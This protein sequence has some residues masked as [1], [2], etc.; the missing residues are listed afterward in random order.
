MTSSGT[1]PRAAGAIADSV[2]AAALSVPGVTRLHTG[3]FGEVAT[4]LPGRRVEGVRLQGGSTEVH[5]VLRPEVD[6]LRTAE[7]VRAV[8]TA[9]VGGTVDVFVE[10]LGT[11]TVVSDTGAAADPAVT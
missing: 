7:A 5:L 4:Y 10:D 9:L 8:V 11:A 6:L 1:S 2:A 3:S